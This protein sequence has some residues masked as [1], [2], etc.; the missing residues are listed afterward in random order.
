MEIQSAIR[1]GKPNCGVKRHSRAAGRAILCPPRD[2]DATLLPPHE[3]GGGFTLV[4]LLVVVVIISIMSVAIIAEMRGTFQDALL[5]STSRELAG[6]F[7]LASSRAISVNRP[8]RVRLDTPAHR[9]LLERSTRGGTDFY[10]VRDLPGSFGTLDSRIAIVVR[11]PGETSTDDAGD[12][13]SGDSPKPG[14]LPTAGLEEAVTFYPDGTADARQ[15]ELADRDG[16]RL[17]L[18]INPVTS[19]VQITKMEH[20]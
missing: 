12:E 19:R 6:A 13:P 4:E 7:N 20:P 2:G 3:L 1:N 9:W 8:L 5:R 17:A 18:R 11:K 14:E 15:I 10:P 16:F